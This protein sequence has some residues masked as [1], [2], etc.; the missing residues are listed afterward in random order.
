VNETEHGHP[1]PRVLAQQKWDKKHGHTTSQDRID[2]IVRTCP[3][4]Y[5]RKQREAKQPKRSHA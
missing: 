1:C 5:C 4:L 3:C 2:F